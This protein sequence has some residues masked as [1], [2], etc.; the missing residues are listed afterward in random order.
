MISNG[1]DQTY[2]TIN[3]KSQ[4][5]VLNG[6]KKYSLTCKQINTIRHISRDKRYYPSENVITVSGNIIK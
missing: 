6:C 2:L 4:H 5:R 3:Q 1:C